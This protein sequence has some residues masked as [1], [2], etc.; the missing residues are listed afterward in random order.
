MSGQGVRTGWWRNMVCV[1]TTYPDRICYRPSV[2][3]TSAVCFSLS[4][5][6]QGSPH[7]SSG[8]IRMELIRIDWRRRYLTPGWEIWMELLWIAWRAPTFYIRISHSQ[9]GEEDVPCTDILHPDISQPDGRGERF[10]FSGQ[11]YP[12]LLITLTRRVFLSVYSAAV[13]S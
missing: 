2:M 9:M 10:N 5:S 11:T 8:G 12:D 13:F 7:M 4:E 1:R 6:G 3:F